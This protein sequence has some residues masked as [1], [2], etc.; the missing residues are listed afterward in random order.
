M[1]EKSIYEQFDRDAW[2][3]LAAKTPMPL[4]E[5]DLRSLAALGDPIDVE[6]ADAVYRPLSALLRYRVL[7][8]RALAQ[9]Q[10]DFF[11][12]PHKRK[13]PFIIGVA[14][15]VAV[16]K[17]TTSRILQNLLSRWPEISRVALVTTDG[18][19][20]P[21]AELERR[22]LVARK[23]FPE[24]Y[25]RRALLN[26]VTQVKAGVPEV[27]AP[28]YSHVT[29]DIVPGKSQMVCAPDVLIL[30]GLNVLA[31]PL[32]AS[33]GKNSLAVSD[34]FDFS[35]YLH[36]RPADIEQWYLSR[37]RQLRTTAFKQPDSFFR[38]IA[39][40]TDE[41]AESHA[42]QIW[43][44]VNLRNLQENVAPTRS[45]ATLILEKDPDHRVHRLHLRKI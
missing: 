28:V 33:G 18:F 42:R 45:R 3:A 44:E 15:S 30:E 2:R 13:I 25:N 29:Y 16:G 39:A 5:A 23:G 36:A 9:D 1:A 6:E 38:E 17:S 10:Q 40:W 37:F 41:Q 35:I 43:R 34:F 32:I 31:P 8:S 4:T 24:S 22:G 14:G 12:R 11:G 19:L 7:H 27:K 26:F 21:N 20:Y